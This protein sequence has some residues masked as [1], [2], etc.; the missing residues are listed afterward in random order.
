M[1]NDR[2]LPQERR[3]R[4]RIDQINALDDLSYTCAP[5]SYQA[6]H[7][8]EIK[9]FKRL[10]AYRKCDGVSQYLVEWEPTWE[11]EAVLAPP[12]QVA[13]VQDSGVDP[14]RIVSTVN[15]PIQLPNLKV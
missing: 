12:D 11:N 10:L 9:T 6:A 13:A 5:T 15:P 7:A 4:A 14:R 2:S 1:A 3:V 8:I